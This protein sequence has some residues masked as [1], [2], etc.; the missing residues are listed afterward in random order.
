VVVLLLL[1]LL[2]LLLLLLLQALA[3]EGAVRASAQVSE[4]C[5][6]LVSALSESLLS[7]L[8]AGLVQVALT[9]PQD[10]CQVCLNGQCLAV[11]WLD[12]SSGHTCVGVGGGCG[13][14]A[15]GIKTGL[16]RIVALP[17]SNGAGCFGHAPGLARGSQQHTLPMLC[18][19]PMAAF[20]SIRLY[21]VTTTAG[22]C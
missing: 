5:R 6:P 19:S 15:T 3:A 10:P 1:W 16:M 18:V 20:L 9:R 13:M 21:V 8:M 22:D 2:L 4:A 12:P 14:A 17:G 11:R 7:D